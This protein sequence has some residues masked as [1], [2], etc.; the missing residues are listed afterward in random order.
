MYA[1]CLLTHLVSLVRLEYSGVYWLVMIMLGV[2]WE[3]VGGLFLLEAFFK[4]FVFWCYFVWLFICWGFSASL[5][6]F[7]FLF[8]FFSLFRW[9]AGL[10]VR[11]RKNI[12]KRDIVQQS[13][14]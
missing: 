2:C 3:F 4:L 11:N 6:M 8:F 13:P 12:L 7:D 10:A 9:H 14:S 1:V 5:C